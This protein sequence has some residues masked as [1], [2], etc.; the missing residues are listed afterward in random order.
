M[1]FLYNDTWVFFIAGEKQGKTYQTKR[2]LNS[3]MPTIPKPICEHLFILDP[4]KVYADDFNGA[5]LIIPEIKDYNA[6]WLDT[7]LKVVRSYKNALFV[8][9]D[10]DVFLKSG[11]DSKELD[12]LGKTIRQQSIGGI[13]HTHR[14][15]Y[16]NS[17]IFQICDYVSVGYNLNASDTR[18]LADNIN[19]DLDLYDTLK[20]RQ[21]ILVEMNDRKKQ[22]II[23]ELGE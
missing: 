19:L 7:V 23:D 11:Y 3:I 4:N 9:D 2:L 1:R 10:I 18:Y 16:F 8:A 21:F 14:A 6:D 17:R 20:P 22:H 15:K 13:L 12:L 5:E